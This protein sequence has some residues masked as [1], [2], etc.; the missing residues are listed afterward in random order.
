[1]EK[2]ILTS[3]VLQGL[4]QLM[5]NLWSSQLEKRIFIEKYANCVFIPTT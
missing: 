1:M 3:S 2:A 5:S 4:K